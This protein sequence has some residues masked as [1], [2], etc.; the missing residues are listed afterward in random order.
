MRPRKAV[1][2]D[3]DNEEDMVRVFIPARMMTVEVTSCPVSLCTS[4][5]ISAELHV[6]CRLV[7][8]HETTEH[9]Q[10]CAFQELIAAYR[11]VKLICRVVLL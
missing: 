11:D 6:I 10:L 5:W 3:S 7:S 4:L 8:G 1:I 2:L 9:Y